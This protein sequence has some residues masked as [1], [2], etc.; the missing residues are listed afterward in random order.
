LSRSDG[1]QLLDIL[2][3]KAIATRFRISLRGRVTGIA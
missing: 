3:A 1:E 2:D